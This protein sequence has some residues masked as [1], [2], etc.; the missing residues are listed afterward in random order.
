MLCR[1]A[2]TV[3]TAAAMTAAGGPVAR[4]DVGFLVMP[5]FSG[6]E[7]DGDVHSSKL[8]LVRRGAVIASSDDGAVSVDAPAPRRL[9]TTGEFSTRHAQVRRAA[10]KDVSVW[11]ACR[12]GLARDLS[13]WVA[14]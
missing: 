8:D 2:L 7:I 11:T 1:L 10:G 12:V 5:G 6:A 13:S 14:I 9:A 4:A 3:L